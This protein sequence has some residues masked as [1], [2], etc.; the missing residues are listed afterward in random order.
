VLSHARGDALVAESVLAA[1]IA[2]MS[3]PGVARYEASWRDGD[4]AVSPR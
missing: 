4:G 2:A 1:L 3:R